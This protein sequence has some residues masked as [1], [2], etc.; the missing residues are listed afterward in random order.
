MQARATKEI[1]VAA[2]AMARAIVTIRPE[3]VRWSSLFMQTFAPAASVVQ[4]F[5]G[6]QEAMRVV[7]A[8]Q[9]R[10]ESPVIEQKDV[11]FVEVTEHARV[12]VVVPLFV[13]ARAALLVPLSELVLL[14]VEEVDV[15]N[16]EEVVEDADVE[17]DVVVASVLEGAVVEVFFADVELVLAVV[18]AV[19]D[20]SD[21][22]LF[23]RS[24]AESGTLHSWVNQTASSLEHPAAMKQG[25][26]SSS[27]KT[28]TCL[29]RHFDTNS[30][31]QG[32]IATISSIVFPTH[33][34]A[35]T[36]VAA[37]RRPTRTGRM[38]AVVK[39]NV[40]NEE[41]NAAALVRVDVKLSRSK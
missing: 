34:E 12:P 21:V 2:S 19:V 23:L 20:S 24:N 7:V 31:P 5:P 13:V 16:V 37:A 39:Q 25:S 38:L 41:L 8:T 15:A 35:E 4:R 33:S 10:V 40:K 27:R 32:M 11:S 3:V 36:A 22:A 28:S 14:V 6:A 1:I 9:P 29:C 26:I 18:F 30:S 17:E